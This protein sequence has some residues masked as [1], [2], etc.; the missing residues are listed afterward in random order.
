M[1]SM[2]GVVFQPI[3]YIFLHLEFLN[4]D[5]VPTSIKSGEGLKNRALCNFAKQKVLSLN[6]SETRQTNGCLFPGPWINLGKK[7]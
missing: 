3:R 2:S 4:P 6:F 7:M 5:E 1:F